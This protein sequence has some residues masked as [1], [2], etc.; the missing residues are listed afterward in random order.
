MTNTANAHI[1]EDWLLT[2]KE[3]DIS[4]ILPK[5]NH[6]PPKIRFQKSEYRW[7]EEALNTNKSD[8]G[9]RIALQIWESHFS[10]LWT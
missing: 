9:Q 4:N 2:G 1:Y 7:P 6:I 8:H 3:A 10:V 5:K